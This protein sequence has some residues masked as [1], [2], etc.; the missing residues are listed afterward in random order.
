MVI[1][2]LTLQ[3][4]LTGWLGKKV[5]DPVWKDVIEKHFRTNGEAIVDTVQAWAKSAEEHKIS[6]RRPSLPPGFL[7]AGGPFAPGLPSHFVK[8]IP[9]IPTLARDFE[10]ALQKS[11]GI[12][13]TNTGN[14]T[15]LGGGE[16]KR[17]FGV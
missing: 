8:G 14:G 11:F 12:V 1:Q 16:S 17:K 2:T 3:Y 10:T 6:D 5:A 15:V 13:N 4:A 7:V 9:R